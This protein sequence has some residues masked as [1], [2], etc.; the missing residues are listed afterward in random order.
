MQ[1]SHD[2]G[3]PGLI[4]EDDGIIAFQF[5]ARERTSALQAQCVCAPLMCIRLSVKKLLDQQGN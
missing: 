1:K 2:R 5:P 3:L 4:P